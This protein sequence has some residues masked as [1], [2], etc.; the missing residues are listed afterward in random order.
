MAKPVFEADP[1]TL[2][3]FLL[4]EQQ[5]AAEAT[6]D[7]TILMTSIQ[8]ACK[9]ISTAVR[10]AGIS[11]LYGLEGTV[12][13]QGEEVKKLD[14]ISHDNF[15]NAIRSS[16]KACVLVSEE[17]EDPIIITDEKLRGRYCC[18]FD[19][20]DGSSNIDCNVSV[21]SIFAIYKKPDNS[22]GGI[23][24]ILQ[25][26]NK[27]V[28]AGYCM[29]GSAT[30]MVL[31][32]GKGVHVFTLDPSVGEFLITMENVKI[33]EKPKT[34]YSINEGNAMYWHEPIKR[35]VEKVKS[36]EKPYSARYVGSMVADV[37]RTLLYGGIFMYPNDKKTKSGK[38]RLLYEGNPMAFIIEQAGGKATTGTQRILDVVPKDI[39]ERVPTILGCKRDVDMVLEEYAKE[40]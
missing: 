21:G 29:Y 23:N 39:H 14:I 19:P 27:L 8:L 40:N 31:S 15:V 36:A 17:Q 30:Q 32:F 5:K 3:R 33:P 9:V 4:S 16:T 24:D 28:A 26:G 7:F 6:G 34:I 2:T 35:F 11:G 37:H 12:N 18:A 22:P 1:I 10:K 13:V 38:L 20:L 25:P